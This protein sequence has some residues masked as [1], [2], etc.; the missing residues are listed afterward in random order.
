MQAFYQP[1]HC[2]LMPITFVKIP[3]TN[4]TPLTCR[5]HM[6]AVTVAAEVSWSMAAATTRG[7]IIAVKAAVS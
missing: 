1:K 7:G 4:P 3:V 2:I 5:E 6:L